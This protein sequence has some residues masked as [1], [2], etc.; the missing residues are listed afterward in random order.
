MP[1]IA[2][3]RGSGRPGPD[4][5]R[6]GAAAG[7]DPARA[8][9]RRVRHPRLEL[10]DAGHEFDWRCR[11]RPTA[12]CSRARFGS[13]TAI[14]NTLVA[15]DAAHPRPACRSARLQGRPVQHRRPGPVPDRRARP[16]PSGRRRSG[17]PAAVIAIPVALARRARSPA[18]SG[19]SS[20]APSRRV[21]GAHEVVTTIMLNTIAIRL[22]AFLITGPLRPRA[23]RSPGPATSATRRCRS[24]S[25]DN[26]PPRGPPRLA[27]RPVDLVAAV[28]DARSGSRSG[29]S[30]RTRTPPATPACGP[31]SS[32]S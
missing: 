7:L 30:G 17:R 4:L 14:V 12:R 3:G 29:P 11:S 2:A 31:R 24:S 10:V 18:P 8:G 9:R 21:A 19:A 32:S 16:R 6:R 23:S 27:R 22:I 13:S 5:A 28:P 15:G 1:A 20:R 25:A 26:R